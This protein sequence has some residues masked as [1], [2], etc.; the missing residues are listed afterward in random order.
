MERLTQ[1]DRKGRAWF[2][3][4]G[5]LIR[6]ANGAFHLKRDMTAHYIHDRFVALDKVLDRLAAYEDTGLEPEDVKAL[7]A[8]QANAP[9]TLDE[10]LEMPL[11]EWLWIDVTHPTQRYQIY[12]VE[13]AYYRICEDYTKGEALCCGWPGLI[14]EFEYKDYG[15]TWLAY[16]R[17]PE[18]VKAHE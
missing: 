6:G 4:D 18:G 8:E 10:L 7:A 13:S 5:V 17:K 16:R 11:R 2:D 3:N 15:K 1:R 12:A 9:L 14:F